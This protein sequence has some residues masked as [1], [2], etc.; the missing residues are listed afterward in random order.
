MKSL[1]E[2]IR[3]RAV[4]NVDRRYGYTMEFAPS[5]HQHKL[6]YDEEERRL[7]QEAANDPGSVLCGHADRV[8]YLGGGLQ[9]CFAC[10]TKLLVGG[11]A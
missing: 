5:P 1:H 8:H 11:H 3:E 6:E 2:T 4:E 7:L 9:V 10:W